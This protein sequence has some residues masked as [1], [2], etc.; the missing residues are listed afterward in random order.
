MIKAKEAKP[1]QIIR[2]IL[3]PGDAGGTEYRVTERQDVSG[4]TRVYS[5]FWDDEKRTR[6]CNLTKRADYIHNENDCIVIG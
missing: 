5:L 3:Y 6:E 2:V 1:G 4:K